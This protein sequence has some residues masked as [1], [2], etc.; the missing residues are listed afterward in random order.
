MNEVQALAFIKS[1][2]CNY[3]DEKKVDPSSIRII[4]LT[5]MG[6]NGFMAEAGEG[7][8]IYKLIGN[9]DSLVADKYTKA[10]SRRWLK[11]EKVE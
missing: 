2:I 7:T 5:M 3:E 9:A 10:D 4:S 11:K 6:D 8:N 1:A